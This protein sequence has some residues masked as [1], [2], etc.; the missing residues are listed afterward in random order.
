MI[1]RLGFWI[2]LLFLSVSITAYSQNFNETE[3]ESFIEEAMSASHIPGLAVITF[4]KSNVVYEG[5]FGIADGN[6]TPVTLDTPFQLG[7][8][9]KSFTALL[10][11]QLAAEGKLDLDTPVTK[12]VPNFRTK[13][14]EAWREITVRHVL[15]HISGL[16]TLDGNR[17]Q[18]EDYR[19][20]D[21]LDRAVQSLSK[22]TLKSPPG[23]QFEYSNANY[24]MA[25]LIVEK[26]TGQRFENVMHDRIFAPLGMDNSYVQM[27]LGES[28][29]E[30]QEEAIGFRQWFGFSIPHEYIAGRAM[31]GAGGVTA[32]ARDLTI[33]VQAVAQ[34]DP[35]II[36]L[37]Y[38]DEII[39]PQSTDPYTKD[40]YGFGWFLAGDIGEEPD[41][42]YVSHS[43]LNGGF[44]AHAAF[45]PESESGAIVLT[46]QSGSL[47][48][49]VPA[50]IVKKGLGLPTGPTT[51]TKG[52][53][54][55]L[56]GLLGTALTLFGSFAL[57]THRFSAYAKSV[58]RVNIFRRV[59]PSL[60]LF[61]LAFCLIVIIP[62]MNGITLSGLKVFYPDLWLCFTLS[63]LTAILWGVTRL[64]YPQKKY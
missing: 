22:A 56:W 20:N 47:Q 18:D 63:A 15:S 10:I 62:R 4:D 24:M 21:A 14:L 11:A 23:E 34:K 60:L 49:D 35:R 31:M 33:Y 52:Q 27:L 9:S 61:G 29:K 45:F 26:V 51:P 38:A 7:S 46:N 58:E 43:G 13:D 64:V 55:I 2:T 54:Y 30:A 5:T 50:I 8:V 39:S 48:A 25:A 17:L 36:P 40:G 12:Y 6:K 16:S 44:A 3:F 42:R 28:I 32:S 1:E 37:E 57:S 19:G 53:H 41:R 59:I